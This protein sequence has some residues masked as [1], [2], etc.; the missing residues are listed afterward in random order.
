MYLHHADAVHLAFHNVAI[1]MEI[2]HI[3]LLL[4]GLVGL[5]LI[6]SCSG[7][8]GPLATIVYKRLANLISEKSGQSYNMTL[9]WLRCR[10]S[11]SLLRSAVT[12]L[13]GSR[14]SY[15]RFKFTDSAINLAC[16]ES[17]LELDDN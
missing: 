16:A 3:I 4:W 12:C 8:M 5:Y 17:H 9:Y 14:S 11:F 10:L 7:R 13:R 1:A 15:H 6:F 2:P